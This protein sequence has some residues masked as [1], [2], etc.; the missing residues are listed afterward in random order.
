MNEN[1]TPLQ[2]IYIPRL[3]KCG[4]VAADVVA[5]RRVD[6]QTFQRVCLTWSAYFISN[7]GDFNRFEALFVLIP[8]D[9]P[10]VPRFEQDFSPG[11]ISVY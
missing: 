3:A 9:A 11:W 6:F 8:G 7:R 1:L 2:R 10:N 4:H 5:K